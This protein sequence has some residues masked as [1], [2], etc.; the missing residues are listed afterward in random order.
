MRGRLSAFLILVGLGAYLLSNSNTPTTPTSPQPAA[1]SKPTPKKTIAYVK[2]G[3]RYCNTT[4]AWDR[5]FELSY[6][7]TRKLAIGSWRSTCGSAFVGYGP[8]RYECAKRKP[9]PA[10][11]HSHCHL[12]ASLRLAIRAHANGQ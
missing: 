1:D 2:E 3:W 4:E 11:H 10:G 12:F 6:K 8:R 9:E 5:A 7:G